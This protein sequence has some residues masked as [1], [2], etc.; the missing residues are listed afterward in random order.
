[1]YYL[2]EN[3]SMKRQKNVLDSVLERTRLF[4]IHWLLIIV[5]ISVSSS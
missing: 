5:L 1:M 2:P 4:L 3:L